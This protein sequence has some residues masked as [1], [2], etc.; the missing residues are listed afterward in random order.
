M[1][2]TPEFV[3]A[4]DLGS[5]SFH[6]LVA[7]VTGGQLKVLDKHKEMVRL[8]GGL[9]AYGRL[10]AD[11]EA[12]AMACLE[13]FGQRLKHL[14]SGVVRAVG[15]NTLRRMKD[16]D[17]FLQKAREALGHPVDV[18]G[19]R[20][21]ARLIYIG[22][23]HTH[24]DVGNG[25]LV[26]DIG[27]G[28]TELI[29]GQRFEPGEMDSLNMGCVNISNRFFGNGKLTEKR[30]H[31]ADMQARLEVRPVE[32]HYRQ[33]EWS[34]AVG[35]SGTAKA[36]ARISEAN[37]WTTSGITLASLE[38]LRAA[39]I[40]AGSV[41]KLKIDGLSEE[42]APVIAGGLVV[43][44]AV[45]KA[46][47]ID[48]MSVSDGALREGLM[49]DMLGR[50]EHDDVRALTLQNFCQRFSV[51]TDHAARVRDA[52]LAIFDQ[53]AANWDLDPEADRPMLSWAATLHEIGLAIAHNGYH[54]H[55][56]Y[57]LDNADMPGF[58]RQEQQMLAAI[59]Q[60]HRRKLRKRYFQELPGSLK[61]K[62]MRLTVLLRLAALLHRNRSARRTLP[63]IDFRADDSRIRLDFPA[64]WLDDHPLTQADLEREREYLGR[65]GIK[66]SYA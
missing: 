65:S 52:A 39:L 44:R 47:E 23:A 32:N 9:D 7:R 36:L 59:V 20:E 46:L 18:I 24:A 48:H 29:V 41:D 43:M 22:V 27:G 10:D 51:D 64:G 49:Y 3:A 25:R 53:V 2:E 35:A 66:L 8:G 21:E 54:K 63:P 38:K 33:L 61:A 50:R 31:R 26:V 4:I 5:N 45:F 57:V 28:S 40:D 1:T 14:P 56:A 34:H 19:G 16:S 37:G 11:T 55:G 15:T 42:R 17:A 13:R 12:R 60:G 62:G 58:S 30:M 6:M